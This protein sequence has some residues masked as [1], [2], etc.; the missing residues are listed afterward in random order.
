MIIV[1]FGQPNS[2]KSTLAMGL[3]KMFMHTHNIDGDEFRSVFQNQDYSK[4]GRLRN[5]SKAVD[6]G[7]YLYAKGMCDNLVYSMNFPYKETRDYLRQYMPEAVFVYLHYQT[8]RGREK[9]HANDFEI[10]SQE[11]AL[12]LDT[13][14]L[15]IEQCIKQIINQV[16][17]K[18]R[19]GE[20]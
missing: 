16:A 1:L 8:P 7:Y 17:L 15:T 4:E 3:E 11:E 19:N 10:P 20:K 12:H 5:L 9:Y 18:S 13:E 2:G 14:Q 6:V